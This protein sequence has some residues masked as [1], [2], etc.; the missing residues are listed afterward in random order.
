MRR[1]G[2]L[3]FVAQEL[4]TNAPTAF[5][6]SICGYWLETLLH[7]DLIAWVFLIVS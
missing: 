5:L 7:E 2:F 3:D 4:K 1:L 6:L